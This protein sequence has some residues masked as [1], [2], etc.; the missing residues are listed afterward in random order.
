MY[1]FRS[2]MKMGD[3]LSKV[4]IN[5][6]MFIEFMKLAGQEHFDSH[7][8]LDKPH[9]NYAL[10]NTKDMVEICK[11]RSLIKEDEPNPKRIEVVIK[12]NTK[13]THMVV[14]T[15]NDTFDITLRSKQNHVDSYTILTLSKQGLIRYIKPHCIEVSSDFNNIP[16]EFWSNN[17][18]KIKVIS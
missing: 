9:F 7:L 3:L 8:L 15:L 2:G 6:N 14:G 1:K 4:H 13:G 12:N 11:K 18:S 10:N 17:D 16:K 5:M